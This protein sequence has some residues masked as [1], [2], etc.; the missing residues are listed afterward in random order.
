MFPA[1]RYGKIVTVRPGQPDDQRGAPIPMDN[2][3]GGDEVSSFRR[4]S[5]DRDGRRCPM[6]IFMIEGGGL[7]CLLAVAVFLSACEAATGGTQQK[8]MNHHCCH[9]AGQN[10]NH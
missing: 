7:Y 6:N 3:G 8:A 2:S 9:R 5:F 4:R 10:G 1:G